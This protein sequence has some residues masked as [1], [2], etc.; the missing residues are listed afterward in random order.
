MLTTPP[1]PVDI[2]AHFEWL[3]EFA[4]TAI[5][6]HPR[7]SANLPAHVSKMGG[8]FFWPR[9]VPWPVCHARDAEDLFD[10]S[11]PEKLDE[12]KVFL[13]HAY[14]LQRL[15]GFGAGSPRETLNHW[16]NRQLEEVHELD[17][18]GRNGHCQP[19]LPML[20]LRRDE[21][22]DFPFPNDADL[23]QLLWCPYVHFAGPPNEPPGFL[24]FWRRL[25]DIE[26]P[27]LVEPHTADGIEL[28]ECRLSPECITEY[29]VSASFEAHFRA[30]LQYWQPGGAE[31][32][33]EALSAAPGVKLFGYPRWIGDA[34]TPFC[35]CGRMMKI[36]V[37]IGSEEFGARP[38]ELNRWKPA[39]ESESNLS[40]G[41]S[42]G[43]SGALYLFYCPA[44]LGPR[45][46]GIV[47]TA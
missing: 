29:P 15:A 46:Q 16:V 3:R 34:A 31:V 40:H 17:R 18:R 25:A 24:V 4:A 8:L 14:E 37:T 39:E 23:F 28:F 11:R 9:A 5:R 12:L 10:L 30:D 33:D 13:G 36:L 43:V 35:I 45:L 22:P 19:Y 20:Q 26:D 44:C 32:Y 47:Q 1:P 27:L 2:V 41:L 6:L 21:F 38:A 7:R 42:I